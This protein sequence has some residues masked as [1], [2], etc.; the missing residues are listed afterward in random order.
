MFEIEL[1]ICIKMD[2]GVGGDAE[3]G[4]HLIL[5]ENVKVT[6]PIKCKIIFL[7]KKK[8]LQRVRGSY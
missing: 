1:F 7:G 5:T 6:P 2:L 3:M 8:D 4:N